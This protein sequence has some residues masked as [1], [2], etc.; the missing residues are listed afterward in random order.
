V[1]Q[2]VIGHA[3]DLEQPAPDAL[4][5]RPRQPLAHLGAQRRAVDRAGGGLVLIQR[6]CV[7]GGEPAVRSREVCHDDV[8]MQLRIPGARE[9]VPVRRRHEPLAAHPLH[10]AAAATGLTGFPPQV[11][12]GRSDGA[13]VRLD[14]RL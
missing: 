6:V 14:Q 5:G 7:E 13:F 11:C 4:P 1:P 9:T 2:H 10:T 3:V 8:P 12:H